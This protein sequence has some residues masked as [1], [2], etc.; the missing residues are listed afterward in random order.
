[1]E[2]ES[3]KPSFFAEGKTKEFIIEG[4]TFVIKRLSFHENN[5]ILEQCSVLNYKTGRT[6]F[7]MS[8][9]RELRLLSSLV[10]APFEITEENI[11]KLDEKF[12]VPL[13]NEIEGSILELGELKKSKKR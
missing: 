10:T 3:E 13:M 9:Y 1:M 11:A 5:E 8:K 4:L 6:A 7:K 12:Y 2:E